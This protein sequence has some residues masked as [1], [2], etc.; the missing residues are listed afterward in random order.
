[1]NE[2][3]N[4]QPYRD[5]VERVFRR[6]VFTLSQAS[7][8]VQKLEK[9]QLQAELQDF[10][11]AAS[12]LK[13]ILDVCNE[14]FGHCDDS[15]GALG[16]FYEDC[17]KAF[18][19]ALQHCNLA[20]EP[21][22]TDLVQLYLAEDYGQSDEIISVILEQCRDKADDEFLER[23]AQAE[24]EAPRGYGHRDSY[25]R[26]K[27]INLLLQFYDRRGYDEQYL[28]WCHKK[29]PKMWMRWAWAAEKLEMMG[30]L[31][32]AVACYQEG[33]RKSGY[34]GYLTDRLAE[35]QQQHEQPQATLDQLVRKH[36]G[37]LYRQYYGEIKHLA[38]RL[39]LWDN[40][41]RDRVLAPHEA[42]TYSRET[43]MEL[44]LEEGEVARA[45]AIAKKL[46]LH[47]YYASDGRLTM[48]R[49]LEERD[50]A[51]A[52]ELYRSLLES[53]L[54]PT[55]PAHDEQVVRY[56]R[57]MSRLYQRLG[58]IDEWEN[59][60]EGLKTPGRRKL[61]TMLNRLISDVSS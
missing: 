20:R 35:M 1:M 49:A 53:Y 6:P 52:I 36:A 11:P 12:M 7:R 26:E 55:E 40:A 54:P 58:R 2:K 19:A 10:L 38:R 31:D 16:D 28:A 4:P 27:L 48:A 15:Y 33:I 23:I 44:L 25:Q 39:G 17:L 45:L 59:Y 34:Q 51:E 13:A 9:L 22:L 56:S 42:Q 43:V 57:L 18:S 46:P 50:P 60:V 30:R 8:A 14:E 24:Y 21:L 3:L 32:E 29:D 37:Y 61:T 47:R 41:L 5:P